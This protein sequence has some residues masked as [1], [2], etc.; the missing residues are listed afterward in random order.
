MQSSP[1]Q[2]SLLFL[3]YP[4]LADLHPSKSSLGLHPGGI[5]KTAIYLFHALAGL[6]FPLNCKVNYKV[7]GRLGPHLFGFFCFLAGVFGRGSGIHLFFMLS[8]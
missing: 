7:P 1:G 3:K 6:G 2:H 4:G 5:I 8:L